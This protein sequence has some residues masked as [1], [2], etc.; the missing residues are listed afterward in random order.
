MEI[1]RSRVFLVDKD[2]F[3]RTG[4]DSEADVRRL[5]RFRNQLGGSRVRLMFYFL[6]VSD[7]YIF[8]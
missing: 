8:L 3:A 6:D 7:K 1:T 2:V 5:W 4:L